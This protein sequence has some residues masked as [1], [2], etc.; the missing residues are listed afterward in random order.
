MEDRSENKTTEE[1]PEA[2][3]LGFIA[4]VRRVLTQAGNTLNETFAIRNKKVP[5]EEINEQKIAETIL[6]KLGNPLR[7]SRFANPFD[8][9]D[10]IANLGYIGVFNTTDYL[11]K[12]PDVYGKT[13]QALW[14]LEQDGIIES[15]HFDE[16]DM[17][18]ETI[19]YKVTDEKKLQSLSIKSEK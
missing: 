3:N 1:K 14:S 8:I 18:G 6:Q 7:E 13:K 5:I 12:F 15:K 2:L 17:R 16:P 9:T 11:K 10:V 19:E 4:S